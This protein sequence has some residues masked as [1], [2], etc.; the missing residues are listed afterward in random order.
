MRT[1]WRW[2]A[3]GFNERAGAKPVVSGPVFAAG[4]FS[5]LGDRRP[6]IRVYSRLTIAGARRRAGGYLIGTAIV[7]DERDR[8][9]VFAAL[10]NGTG[11]PCAAAHTRPGGGTGFRGD[12]MAYGAGSAPAPLNINGSNTYQFVRGGLWGGRGRSCVSTT[13]CGS[14]HEK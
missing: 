6:L 5:A 13:E 3:L 7:V 8:L 11:H 2:R 4:V 14:R 10:G 12:E 1:A 9:T